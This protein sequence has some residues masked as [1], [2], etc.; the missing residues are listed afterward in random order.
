MEGKK[1][2]YKKYIKKKKGKKIFFKRVKKCDTVLEKLS[3][4]NT[5]CK[6]GYV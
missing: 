3:E 6:I 4:K 2:K 1:A 5:F